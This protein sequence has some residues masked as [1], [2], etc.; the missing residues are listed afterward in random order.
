[1]STHHQI[2]VIGGGIV[3]A[4]AAY[5]LAKLGW[6]DILVVDKG[7]FEEN[8]GSTSHAPGG[9]VALSHSK[10]LT[11]MGTY[12]SD[13]YRSV[14][15]FD[16][17][18]NT[19]NAVGG[20]ELAVTHERW[21]D[22]KRLNGEGR[23]FGTESFLLTPQ[24]TK[25]KL[26]LLNEKLVVGSL[27]VP[28][29]AIVAGSHLANALLRDSGAK[30][31][32]ATEIMDVEVKGGRLTALL[33]NNPEHPRLECEAAVL[34]TNIWG[35]VLGDRVGVPLPLL[36]Y[37][38]QY[39]ITEPLEVL[40]NFSRARKEDEII[41]PTTRSLDHAIYFRP[42]WDSYGI[43]NYRHA[44]RPVNPYAVGRSALRPFTPEDFAAS[45]AVVNELL[46]ATRGAQLT[47]RFNGMF[48]FPVD[49]MPMIGESDV[50][51]FWV[52]VG[53]WLTHAG[54]VGK[55]VAEWLTHGEAEWDMR[56]CHVHRFQPFQNTRQYV[57]VVCNKNYAELYDVIHPR[58]AP[59]F[60][61]DV[62]VSPFAPRWEALKAER[63]VFAGLE[64]P[65]WF[66]ENAR[67]LEK[68]E[69]RIPVR[70]GWANEHWSR[71]QGAEHLATRENVAL[72]DLTGLSILEVKG[73]NAVQFVNYLC[74]NQMD[75]P[76]GSVVYTTWLTPKGGVRR[77]LAVARLAADVFWMFIGEGTLPHDRVWVKDA[78]AQWGQAG[79]TV[80]DISNSFTAL[81]LWGPNARK[82][83]QKVTLQD[84]NHE[85]FPYFTAQW[86]EIGY[87]RVLALRLSYVGELGWE[88]HIPMDA[89][90]PVFDVLWEAGREFGLTAV[91]MGAFDSLRLE[92]G[93]RLWGGDVYTEY[94]AYESGLGWTVKLEKRSN[95]IGREAS[96]KLKAAPLKRKLCCLTLDAPDGVALGN[97]PIFANGQCVGHVTSANYGYSVGKFIVYG[98]LPVEHTAPGTQLEIEY[99]GQRFLA[100]VSADP[101]WDAKMERLKA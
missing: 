77:D 17:A 67:L 37:E 28:K 75:K 66:E 58:K 10:L 86:I 97:E 57:D 7:N 34:C 60:P 2:I 90:L 3:G 20:I 101:Q 46:P 13:L 25:A 40:A 74:S 52:A 56:L 31:L 62:R 4:S 68:Y 70:T 35:P 42:H 72:F 50:K 19:Y 12:G 73:V 48:A 15:P 30:L 55:S 54:G 98:Y 51:G 11:Q 87:T 85:A 79:V 91:G 5:H 53:S 69:E 43:G 27:F 29:S 16:A 65:N 71:I 59:S 39:A 26:P 41:W 33:T 78:L 92:K 18:R 93:Y 83:L 8:D 88:L 64:L 95:F 21:E 14:A 6:R 63:T 82:V 9:V 44:P 100:T 1:M 89:A 32:P 81:G 47:T 23:G 36:A 22:L 99:F 38:H 84:V 94:N 80:N 49:G 24:E 61:R 45:W 96:A 76:V